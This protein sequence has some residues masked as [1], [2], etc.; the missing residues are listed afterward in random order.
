MFDWLRDQ[1]V[2]LVQATFGMLRGVGD[3]ALGGLKAMLTAAMPDHAAHWSALQLDKANVFLPVS[4]TV[5]LLGAWV[6]LAIAVWAYRAVKSWI[7]S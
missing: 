3:D 7:W 6:A 1:L 2:W 5:A 4:E